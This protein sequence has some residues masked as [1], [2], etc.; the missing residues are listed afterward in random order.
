MNKCWRTQTDMD[1]KIITR[2]DKLKKKG[3]SNERI[4]KF[5]KDKFDL[6]LDTFSA[7]KEMYQSGTPEFEMAS[8]MVD[9][10]HENSANSGVAEMLGGVARQVAQGATFAFA[11][12]IEAQLRVALGAASGEDTTY[13]KELKKVRKEIEDF[14][15]ENPGIALVSELTGA[16]AVPGF[17]AAKLLRMAPKLGMIKEGQW[18]MNAFKRAGLGAGAGG[19]EGGIYG[20]GQAE[21][22]LEGR[23]EGALEGAKTGVAL[24]AATGPT[25]GLALEKGVQ[26]L[27]NLKRASGE[28]NITGLPPARD[29]EVKREIL[30]AA[31]E[32]RITTDDILK[33]M[34]EMISLS[35]ELNKT[36]TVG[37]TFGRKSYGEALVDQT[38]T[39][40]GAGGSQ[41]QKNYMDRSEMFPGMAT[42][43]IT[44][45][46]GKK[47]SNEDYFKS[48]IERMSK[49]MAKPLY[50][51]ADRSPIKG[52]ELLTNVQRYWP[53]YIGVPKSKRPPGADD[54][55]ISKLVKKAWDETRLALPRLMKGKG[56]VAPNFP[57]S[58]KDV[59]AEGVEYTVLHWDTFRKILNEKKAGENAKIVGKISRGYIDD[60]TTRI[61]QTLKKQSSDY[62]TAT[63]AWSRGPK[64]SEA[65]EAGL[66]AEK[67]SS[68]SGEEIKRQ[69]R[70]FSSDGKYPAGEKAY[71]LGYA[72]GLHNRIEVPNWRSMKSQDQ[73]LGLL[74]KRKD[75]QIRALFKD[76]DT[77]DEFI[78]RIEHISSLDQKSK[79]YVTNSWTAKKQAARKASAKKPRLI[80][81]ALET[82]G[83]IRGVAP[84]RLLTNVDDLNIAA[85]QS[86]MLNQP[87]R[88]HAQN[89]V[90]QLKT[91][92][93]LDTNQMNARP[94]F[95]GYTAG[96]LSPVSGDEDSNT[97]LKSLLS[98]SYPF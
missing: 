33:N 19:V 71:K 29:K 48:W 20:A 87:G 34:D 42:K 49:I 27:Q 93:K 95:P 82:A 74:S 35:P 72:L 14:K 85:G 73:A 22:G 41:L 5:F 77:A 36:V 2:Y 70:N 88:S 31:N 54:E 60:I 18:V 65:F 58:P 13:E 94:G 59:T 47:V 10:E 69:L 63:K 68:M 39:V 23:A 98:G 11:D 8:R 44:E 30:V 66:K 92:Q 81:K 57:I 21:G 96:L 50:N 91:Q 53:K 40:P 67:T 12:E 15:E 9:A 7:N 32:E 86:N 97:F 79:N 51:K 78:K 62:N 45:H 17:A 52:N 25:L 80:G 16:F 55:E 24:G 90:N 43:E 1:T 46:I 61:T 56:I 6:D 64:Y 76:Q 26:K 38:A 83:R 89:V 3:Y 37:D 28:E 4:K 84:E 75:E